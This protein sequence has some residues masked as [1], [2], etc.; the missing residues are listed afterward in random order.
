M[1]AATSG[2]LTKLAASLR[3]HPE[4][5]WLNANNIEDKV[6]YQRVAHPRVYNNIKPLHFTV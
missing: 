2:P 1:Q 5:H 4:N 6:Y 3:D